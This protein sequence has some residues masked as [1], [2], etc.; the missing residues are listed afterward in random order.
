MSRNKL[1]FLRSL[2]VIS[3]LFYCVYYFLPYFYVQIHDLPAL[4]LLSKPPVDA[5]FEI[6]QAGSI[7]ILL[8][9]I[10]TSVALFF[11]VLYA[12]YIYAVYIVFSMLLTLSGGIVAYPS[13]DLF[14]YDVSTLIDG[15]ILYLA[16][17]IVR[18]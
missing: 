3:W 7:T 15:V 1:N 16:F 11:Q 17:D 13:A 14:F 2:I 8:V 5:L 9:H 12:R 6:S 18:K 4:E 10:L